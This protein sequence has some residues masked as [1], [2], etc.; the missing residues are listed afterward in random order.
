MRRALA[1]PH[2][3]SDADIDPKMDAW[4]EINL[5]ALNTC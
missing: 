1:S 4:F 2:H 5:G 3:L